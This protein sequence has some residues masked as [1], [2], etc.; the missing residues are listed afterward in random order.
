LYSGV[1]G[2][3]QDNNFHA[4]TRLGNPESMKD[5]QSPINID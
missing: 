5:N 3:K 1:I 2:S 4:K